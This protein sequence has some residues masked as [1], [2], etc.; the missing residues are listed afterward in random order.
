MKLKSELTSGMF[1]LDPSFHAKVAINFTSV[2]FV[3]LC[4]NLNKIK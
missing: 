4:G 1:V 3:Q 2:L